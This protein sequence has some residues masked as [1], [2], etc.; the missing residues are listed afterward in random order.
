MYEP[1]AT[2][3]QTADCRIQDTKQGR[4]IGGQISAEYWHGVIQYNL[5]ATGLEKFLAGATEN[6]FS[7]SVV[8]TITKASVHQ[9]CTS[10]PVAMQ[11]RCLLLIEIT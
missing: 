2:L 8:T 3:L 4:N 9:N 6:K 5:K 11:K 1:L 7:G 10:I